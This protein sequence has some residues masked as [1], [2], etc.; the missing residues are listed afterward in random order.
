LQIK[1]SADDPSRTPGD[2]RVCKDRFTECL[3][4]QLCAACW[5]CELILKGRG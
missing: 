5:C 4:M 1:G 3:F 2:V